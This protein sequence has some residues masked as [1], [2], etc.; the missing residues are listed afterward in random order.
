MSVS[1]DIRNAIGMS[2]GDGRDGPAAGS[3]R[4]KND[5]YGSKYHANFLQRANPHGSGFQNKAAVIAG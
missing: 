2:T 3:G 5:P 1:P 4:M